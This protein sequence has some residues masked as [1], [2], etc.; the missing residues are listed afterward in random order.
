MCGRRHWHAPVSLLLF[1]TDTA[2]EN[3]GNRGKNNF[4]FSSIQTENQCEYLPE[5]RFDEQQHVDEFRFTFRISLAYEIQIDD[6]DAD[7]F[8]QIMQSAKKKNRINDS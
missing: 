6:T 1:Q 3:N 8:A 5:C 2:N 7:I 4:E